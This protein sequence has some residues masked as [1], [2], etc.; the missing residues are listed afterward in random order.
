MLKIKSE[1]VND[2]WERIYINDK[3][4]CENHCVAARGLMRALESLD[5]ADVKF[6]E[7]EE[8]D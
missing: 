4:V 6:T 7:V 2:D 3:L 5:L 1:L 8:E